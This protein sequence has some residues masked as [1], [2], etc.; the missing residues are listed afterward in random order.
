MVLDLLSVRVQ[1][2][3][4]LEPLEVSPMT[5]LDGQHETV[6]CEFIKIMKRPL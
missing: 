4:E 1:E 3:M 6:L 5:V 2:L